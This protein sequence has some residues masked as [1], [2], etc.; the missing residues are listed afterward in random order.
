VIRLSLEYQILE[1]L[2]FKV[3]G[4][5]LTTLAKRL[6]TSEEKLSV[7]LDSMV[8]EKKL[9]KKG[10]F[11]RLPKVARVVHGELPVVSCHRIL[12][13]FSGLRVSWDAVERLRFALEYLGKSIATEA[14]NNAK[15][16]KSRTISKGD[17][18]AVASKL[19]LHAI[20]HDPE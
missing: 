16:R 18:D 12:M 1:L 10:R 20:L 8:D 7:I 13:K 4:S 17:I 9:V 14:G 15:S 3:R 6:G 5:T 11:Y 19:G 2:E